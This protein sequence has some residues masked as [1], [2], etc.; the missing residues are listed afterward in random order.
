MV[1]ETPNKVVQRFFKPAASQSISLRDSGSDDLHSEGKQGQATGKAFERRYLLRSREP[2]PE[3]EDS[4]CHEVAIC[5]G[6]YQTHIHTH[7]AGNIFH[8]RISLEWTFQMQVFGP[9][10]TL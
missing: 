3:G 2:R 10:I 9:S 4:S 5:F 1:A 8:E 6:V 7:M